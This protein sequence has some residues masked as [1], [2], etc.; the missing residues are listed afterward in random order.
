[1]IVG[2]CGGYEVGKPVWCE[3]KIFQFSGLRCMLVHLAVWINRFS[4]IT[5]ISWSNL[6]LKRDNS[7][8]VGSRSSEV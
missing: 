8:P 6:K 2:I 7:S 1:M 4:A 3:E 5:M